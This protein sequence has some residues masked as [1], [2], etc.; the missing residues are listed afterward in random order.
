MYASNSEF[1]YCREEKS[2]QEKTGTTEYPLNIA[3]TIRFTE[4][5]WDPALRGWRC[6][7]LNIPGAVIEDVYVNG[8]RVDK[9]TY[10]VLKEHG[11]VRWI[12]A[13]Q[14]E[15]PVASI[16]LTEN[17]T[18]EA[19]TERWKKLAIILPVFATIASATIT[20]FTT[21]YS[22]KAKEQPQSGVHP[23]PSSTAAVDQLSPLSSD[24]EFNL[25]MPRG[26]KVMVTWRGMPNDGS[27]AGKILQASGISLEDV[28]EGTKEA[29]A[30]LAKKSIEMIR[31]GPLLLGTKI[32]PGYSHAVIKP[33]PAEDAGYTEFQLFQGPQEFTILL[34]QNEKDLPKPVA[35]DKI[36]IDWSQ[37][38]AGLK[39]TLEVLYRHNKEVTF[40]SVAIYQEADGSWEYRLPYRLLGR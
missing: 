31:Y 10:E 12:P 19:D 9:A 11:I 25:L 21:Y 32:A 37:V 20:G 27:D 28:D 22:S 15:R 14:P 30:A 35:P 8:S 13:K 4:G 16:R 36:G 3:F 23:A 33:G 7:V 38:R 40:D 18:K 2:C 26:D 6:P 5:D 29:Y 1:G 24:T 34:F 17:L 39:K